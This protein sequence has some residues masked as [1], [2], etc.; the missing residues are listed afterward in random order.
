MFFVNFVCPDKH[1]STLFRTYCTNHS[2]ILCLNVGNFG[3]IRINYSH[4]SFSITAEL[5][6]NKPSHFHVPTKCSK[7]AAVITKLSTD[8][9]AYKSDKLT[10][11][12]EEASVVITDDATGFIANT[13]AVPS[14]L[15][16]IEIQPSGIDSV[17]ASVTIINLHDSDVLKPSDKVQITSVVQDSIESSNPDNQPNEMTVPPSLWSRSDR[18]ACQAE[19]SE[20]CEGFLN[21]A[22]TQEDLTASNTG[23]N[24][25]QLIDRMAVWVTDANIALNEYFLQQMRSSDIP[26]YTNYTNAEP[27][28]ERFL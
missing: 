18:E 21:F 28:A 5:R 9:S 16:T 15:V 6:N 27:S 1:T 11:I 26:S 7:Y 8:V 20:L 22:L 25:A 3:P 17:A 2:R 10:T 13:Y 19:L 23:F 4:P 12:P 14:D 24:P